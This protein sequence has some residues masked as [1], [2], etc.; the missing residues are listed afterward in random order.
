MEQDREWRE[1][2]KPAA[3]ELDPQ[4]LMALIAEITRTLDE[5]DERRNIPR[6]KQKTPSRMKG[7]AI[8]RLDPYPEANFSSAVMVRLRYCGFSSPF[9]GSFFGGSFFAGSFLAG[10]VAGLA[11][12]FGAGL[13]GAGLFAAGLFAAGLLAAGLFATG[14]F[15]PGAGFA[16]SGRPTG[17]EGSV[18]RSGVAGAGL[19][20]GCRGLAAGSPGLAAGW[21]GRASFLTG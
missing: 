11:A 2:C 3:N 14:L 4:K 17:F 20:A 12:G 15:G 6:E 8:A 13:F 19:A 21:A 10:G 18:R 5:R 9:G 7:R 1:L 16:A